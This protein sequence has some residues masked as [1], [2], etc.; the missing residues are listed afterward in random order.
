MAQQRCGPE[1][2]FELLRTV[3]QRRNIKLREV[4]ANLVTA[5]QGDV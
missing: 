3:S 2:A 4:A 5:I 1:E